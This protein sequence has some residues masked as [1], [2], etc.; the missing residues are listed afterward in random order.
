MVYMTAM[1][2]RMI[3]LVFLSPITITN[4]RLILLFL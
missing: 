4:R 1:G 2:T 3:L